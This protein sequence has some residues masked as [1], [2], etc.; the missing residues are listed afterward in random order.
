MKNL[1]ITASVVTH[2]CPCAVHWALYSLLCASSHSQKHTWCRHTIVHISDLEKKELE[3]PQLPA[4]AHS[5][6][7]GGFH[8]SKL[9]EGPQDWGPGMSIYSCLRICQNASFLY[10]V[11]LCWHSSS[12]LDLHSESKA[13][14]RTVTENCMKC[15]VSVKRHSLF[16]ADNIQPWIYIFLKQGFKRNPQTSRKKKS[17]LSFLLLK[18]LIT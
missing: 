5:G 17:Y 11:W 12:S 3:V 2:H 18:H 14:G 16:A 13:K 15:I 7:L 8:S 9:M 10:I 4:R 1:L 6:D